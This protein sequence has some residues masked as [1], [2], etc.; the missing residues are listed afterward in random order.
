MIP[1]CI[2]LRFRPIERSVPILERFTRTRQAEMTVGGLTLTMIVSPVL[3]DAG[4]RLGA[5]VE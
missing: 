2:G 5:V 1:R 3:S 4:D